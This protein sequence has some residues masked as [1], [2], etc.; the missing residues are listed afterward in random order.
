MHLKRTARTR[1]ARRRKVVKPF[2]LIA[3]YFRKQNAPWI[4]ISSYEL[5]RK[6]LLDG[7][8]WTVCFRIHVIGDYSDQSQ[9]PDGLRLE[10]NVAIWPPRLSKK[11][12]NRIRG[13]EWYQHIKESLLKLGYEGDWRTDKG[14]G[15]WALFEKVLRNVASVRKEA[16]QL[17]L[18][19]Q[20]C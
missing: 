17:E 18:L 19:W 20:R 15:S 1:A 2:W 6:V 5:R 11:E 4:P 13:V 16:Q 3:D 14:V 7:Q 9:R 12:Q 8:P 10:A